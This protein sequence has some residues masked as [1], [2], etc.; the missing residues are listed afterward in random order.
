MIYLRYFPRDNLLKR[1]TMLDLAGDHPHTNFRTLF[2]KLVSQGY[3]LEV[4]GK[5]F[6]CF[7]ASLYGA[8]L[9]VDTE[10]EFFPE[11]IEKLKDDV[12]SFY[13]E[14]CRI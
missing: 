9:I 11:E 6:T 8:L 1:H 2:D 13:I 10:E 14:K 4:L 3:Y 5:D 7:D 12:I